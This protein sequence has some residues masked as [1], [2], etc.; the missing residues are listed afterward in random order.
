ML[1]PL[2]ELQRQLLGRA[3]DFAALYGS[4]PAVATRLLDPFG[5][6]RANAALVQRIGK[7][8]PR[9]PFGITD[10]T[11]DGAPVA[12]REHTVEEWPFCRLIRFARTGPDR[13]TQAK[14]DRDPRVL[15][16]APLSGHH[17]TL[18][19]DT[20]A[21]LVPEH[22]VYLTD[23]RDARDVPLAAGDLSLAT[24]VDLLVLQMRR[25][26]PKGLHVVAVCQPTVPA[27][28]A[29]SLLA[30]RG[31]PT[32]RTLT[33]MGGPID[34]RKS[35][36]S[37]TEYGTRYSLAW[38]EHNLVHHVPAGYAGA[39]RRV[40][41]GFLQLAAFMWMNP[42]RHLEAYR[43]F[44]LAQLRGDTATIESHERFYDEYLAVLDMDAQF[45]LDT[46]QLVFQE[47]AL[48][49]GTWRIGDELVDP[50]AIRT[51]AL[52]TIEGELD[53]ISAPGQTAAAHDL[54]SNIAATHKRTLVAEG[55][56]HYGLFSGS[57]WRTNVYPQ[58]HRFIRDYRGED[59]K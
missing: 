15:L 37:V 22:D 40:Y 35:A 8:Y 53:D 48:A 7:S 21:T 27:L 12:I 9:R 13:A 10:T 42:A 49:R 18:L 11:R 51:T 17:P 45:Y 16:C 5:I 19:R 43:D 20:I 1:Y 32:P 30:S 52:F 46:V 59:Q 4:T 29:V 31:E 34:P 24:F 28:A 36:T 41:P 23:W 39:G 33:L 44:W 47:F 25:L 55:C 58:I 14:L 50:S 26:D 54:C 3:A 6:G 38:F 56:G 57:R 2:Y